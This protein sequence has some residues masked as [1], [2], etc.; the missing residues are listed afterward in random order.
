[1]QM[2]NGR[3]QS[4]AEQA[5]TREIESF[6]QRAALMWR[7]MEKEATIELV[8]SLDAVAVSRLWEPDGEAPAVRQDSRFYVQM[9]LA[10]ALRPFLSVVKS[11]AGGVPWTT[12]SMDASNFSYSYLSC[13]GKLAHLRRLA[14]LE[15]YGLASTTMSG[16]GKLRIE[17]RG[18]ALEFAAM[19]AL[20]AWKVRSTLARAEKRRLRKE[21]ERLLRRM[22]SY[23]QPDDR[24]LIRYDNDMEI[25]SRYREDAKVYGERFFEGEAFPDDVRIGDR[26]FGEW[27]TAC[28]QALGRVLC[29]IDFASL[30]Q[31]KSSTTVALRDV[32]TIFARRDDVAAVWREAGLRHDHVE[33]T[34]AALTLNVDG[35]DDWEHAYEAPTPFYV[36]LG[37]DFVLLA[38]FGALTNPYFALFRH[39]RATHKADWDR[40]VDRREDVFRSDLSRLFP[41]PRYL[42]PSRGF[43]VRRP[44]GSR[45]TDI[46]A[47]IF[48]RDSGTCALVQLKWHDVF[49][50]S[51]R[52]RESRRRN[53]ALANEWVRRIVSWIN[54]RSSAEVATALGVQGAGSARPPM[55]YVIARYLACFS[56]EEDQD[57]RATWLGWPEVLRAM[58]EC[59]GTDPLAQL[60]QL[61][62]AHRSQFAAMEDVSEEF[63]FPGI[64]I[65]L[66]ASVSR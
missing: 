3:Q 4:E 25:V 59:D 17:V 51:L 44:D 37:R 10:V 39:L 38:C 57:P 53:I 49:G 65:E 43:Q 28:S 52:E 31:K 62:I 16:P 14:G 33:G 66:H 63:S 18:G 50:R 55:L 56:G 40:A 35:L 42:V 20:R 45:L 64:K 26:T 27:K 22:H 2:K 11:M 6:Q 1:M 58:G 7:G 19:D 24:F 47:V 5:I 12:S 13:C 21:K 29:H 36:D 15:H 46:D 54:D 30:L 8:R 41:A 32:L 34:M 60:P 61:A 48:D 23:V 9:G